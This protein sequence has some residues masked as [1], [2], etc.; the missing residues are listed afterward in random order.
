MSDD[1]RLSESQKKNQGKILKDNPE[2]KKGQEEIV[3]AVI[4]VIKKLK[5]HYD[6]SFID[7]PRTKR[8]PQKAIVESVKK[9][10]G[11]NHNYHEVPEIHRWNRGVIM[12]DGGVVY[13]EIQNQKY[14]TINCF[15]L[16]SAEYK[17]QG[18]YNPHPSGNVIERAFKNWTEYK[19]L[20]LNQM[21]SSYYL[22]CSGPDFKEG[23]SIRD[24]LTSAT[25]KRP[26]NI[27]YYEKIK[28]DSSASVYLNPKTWTC[29]EMAD[30]MFEDSKKIIDRYIM[31]TSI[32]ET[33][34]TF[35]KI[36]KSN[37]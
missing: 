19:M 26:F 33:E 5:S 31:N 29:D 8:I 9:H 17:K 16:F 15:P 24:R 3:K 20:T 36:P 18:V 14:M 7:F 22:F 6:S 11:P 34:I 32:K 13:C 23:S 1:K 27:S 37:E 25:L 2:A 35:V 21:F 28:G 4:S 30:I 12:P 10:Y